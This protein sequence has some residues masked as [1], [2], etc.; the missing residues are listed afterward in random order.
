MK[1]KTNKN[2]KVT[3][4]DLIYNFDLTVCVG[5]YDYY[6]KYVENNHGIEPE[7]QTNW[8]GESQVII[9]ESVNNKTNNIKVESII[10]LPV[11]NFVTSNY[12]TIAHEI[13][14][15]AINV[16]KHVGIKLDY[17]NQEPLNYY[18]DYL[19]ES[20]LKELLKKYKK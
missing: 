14:H 7:E 12:A 17:D 3:V 16:F 10:W 4:R 20:T 8:G 15:I 5:D 18:F 1:K 11:L 13:L 19:F 2:F 6:Q 9:S